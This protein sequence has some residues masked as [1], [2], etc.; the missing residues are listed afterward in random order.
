MRVFP[1]VAQRVSSSVEKRGASSA[2]LLGWKKVEPRVD[3][4]VDSTGT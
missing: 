3:S 1:W 2:E 4:S